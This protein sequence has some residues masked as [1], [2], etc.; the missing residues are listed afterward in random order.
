MAT[1]SEDEIKGLIRDLIA[2]AWQSAGRRN[3]AG[4]LSSHKDHICWKAASALSRLLS[5]REDLADGLR[6]F[7]EL[8]R[9]ITQDCGE[10][11]FALDGGVM[12]AALAYPVAKVPVRWGDFREASLALSRLE[13]GGG[14]AEPKT[15]AAASPP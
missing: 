8:Y 12:R 11:W 15:L 9:Q 4:A 6:P 2:K 3:S 7:A 1:M 5:E 13:P 10:V 14:P